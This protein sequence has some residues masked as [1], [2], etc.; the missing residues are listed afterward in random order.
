MCLQSYA[1]DDKNNDPV[2]DPFLSPCYAS[3][4]LL[5]YFPPCRIMVGNQDPLMDDG[6]KFLYRLRKLKKDVKLT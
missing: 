6:L 5:E 2:N 1:P 3:D 4:E